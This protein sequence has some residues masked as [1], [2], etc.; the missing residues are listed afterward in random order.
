MAAAAT[1][2]TWST[3]DLPDAALTEAYDKAAR[4]NVL[5]AVNPRVFPGYFSVC[6]DGR[7]FGYGNTYPSLDG[8]QMSVTL[9]SKLR[10][11]NDQLHCGGALKLRRVTCFVTS[12][13][14][15]E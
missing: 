11:K 13:P 8:H 9:K 15:T 10:S 1:E 6:A 4:Q 12:R 3:P 5:A 7:G 14:F 2:T